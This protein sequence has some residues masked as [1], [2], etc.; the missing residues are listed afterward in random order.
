MAEATGRL[1]QIC[2]STSKGVVKLAVGQAELRADHGLLGDAHAGAGHRQVSLLD[3]L[4]IESMRAKGLTLEPG[5]FGENLVVTGIALADLAPGSQLRVGGAELEI[6]Q[7]GK[8]CHHRCAIYKTTGD[9]IM[10]RRG[11]F[12]RVQRGAPIQTGDSV[13]VLHRVPA[14][15]LQ[16]AVVT[17]SDRCHR[18]ETVDLAGPAVAR[19]LEQNLS[20]R[21]AWT[22]L[23]ADEAPAIQAVLRDYSGR[24]MDLV[25]TSGGT[26]CAA[27]DVTP[28]ATR[29][30]LER[31]VP[32]LA[33]AMR[34]ASLRITPHAMLQRGVCGIRGHSLIL[35]LPGSPKAAIENLDAV[36]EALPHAVQLLRGETAHAELDRG[37]LAPA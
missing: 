3:E 34:A 7:V 12:A 21:V 13:E 27:R 1:L 30:V 24:G 33:E 37:R 2:T 8:V 17:V 36:R 35:N 16:V 6:T 20:A 15:V 23:V 9:C 28:E 29:A 19:W 25:C 5:A 26:G 11:L 18:G 31:E 4:D 22:A 10:P 14:G 32:G